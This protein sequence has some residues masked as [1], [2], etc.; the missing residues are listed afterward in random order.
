MKERQLFEIASM[1]RSALEET[2]FSKAN[3]GT[4]GHLRMTSFPAGTCN[5]ATTLLGLFLT[6]EYRIESLDKLTAQ[7]EEGNK[8]HGWHHWL[9]HDGVIIDISADQFSMVTD[10]VIVTRNSPF[11]EKYAKSQAL[12]SSSFK[13]ENE[14]DWM[15]VLYEAVLKTLSNQDQRL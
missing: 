8:W 13:L 15:I 4:E 9:N 12:T 7:I 2:D 14:P 6:A 5:E 11:H 10:P 3:V 1:F